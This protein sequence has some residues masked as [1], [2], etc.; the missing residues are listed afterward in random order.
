MM[1]RFTKKA[2]DAL[3][4]AE[5]AAKELGHSYIGT[6]HILIGLIQEGTGV[7][8]KILESYQVTEEKVINL[9]EQLI[10]PAQPVTVEE[11]G[12]YSPTAVKVLNNSYI[13]AR[14][15]KSQLI[16]TEHILI[17][18]LKISECSATRLINTMNVNIRKMYVDLLVAM[19]QDSGVYKEEMLGSMTS[20]RGNSKTP[21]LDQYSRDLTEMAREGKLDPVIEG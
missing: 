15:F 13:E 5:E 3:A 8:A 10:N 1:N 17:A 14:R 9:V 21:I 16:G 2:I 19:G 6:E 20:N 18:I 11:V 7:A 4:C 12:G